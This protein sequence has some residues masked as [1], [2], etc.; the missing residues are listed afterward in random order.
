MAKKKSS[1]DGLM[2]SAGLMRYYDADKRAIHIHPK[3]VIIFGIVSGLVI[4]L[5]NASFGLWP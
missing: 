4:I 5:L 1:G 3:T 2:S